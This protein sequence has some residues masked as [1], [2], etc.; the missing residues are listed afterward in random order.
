M[1]T[2]FLPCPKI[3]FVLHDV[4]FRPFLPA[5]LRVKRNK[6]A[7]GGTQDSGL[8]LLS[9]LYSFGAFFVILETECMGVLGTPFC[10]NL[11]PRPPT[12]PHAKV[13]TERFWAN[14][15]PPP[16]TV[17]DWSPSPQVP[18]DVLE[19]RRTLCSPACL[20]PIKTW[21]RDNTLVTLQHHS[22][23]PCAVFRPFGLVIVQM[24]PV[25]YQREMYDYKRC[26]IKKCNHKPIVH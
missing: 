12:P 22:K 21:N 13:D 10:L 9:L 1:H 17:P 5:Y 11:H 8:K 4:S 19:D 24:Y 16:P 15:P 25:M 7:G 18:R 2:L 3:E 6:A 14:P 26:W 23:C 20:P